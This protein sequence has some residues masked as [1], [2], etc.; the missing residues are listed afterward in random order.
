[1]AINRHSQDI[2]SRLESIAAAAPELGDAVEALHD[3]V[4]MG[5]LEGRP[6]SDRAMV[7]VFGLEMM[8]IDSMY[9][10]AYIRIN[11]AVGRSESLIERF[12]P[13]E[14]CFW[15]ERQGEAFDLL[16]GLHGAFDRLQNEA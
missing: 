11:S 8:A 14:K 13:I 1:M 7:A 5:V 4:A 15:E 10:R 2:V 6:L 12:M 9:V 3:Q 16:V